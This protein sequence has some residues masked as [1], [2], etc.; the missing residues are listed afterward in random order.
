MLVIELVLLVWTAVGLT[1]WILSCWLVSTPARQPQRDPVKPLP[2]LTVFKALPPTATEKD[3]LRLADAIESFLV[4]IEAGSQMI[5]GIEESESPVWKP[6][7]DRWSERAQDGRLLIRKLGPPPPSINPKI[8]K[9]EVLAAHATGECWLWSDAD[10][11]APAGLLRHLRQELADATVGAVTTV[12]VVRS[13]EQLPGM[14]DA[15]FVNLEFLPG[16]LLLGRKGLLDFA[17]GAA[18][19]F[20][21][22]DFRARVP[23]SD[24]RSVLADDYELGQRLGRVR[25]SSSRVETLALSTRWRQALRHYYR[26]QKTIRW[27]RPGG[28][29]ALLTILPFLGWL[30]AALAWPAAAVFWGGLASVWL[31]EAVVAG[32]MFRKLECRLPA[33]SWLLFAAWPP[34][35]ALTWL[36]VWL[37]FAVGWGEGLEPWRQARRGSGRAARR[38]EVETCI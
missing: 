23:W 36:A 3:R 13:P 9:L 22:A 5:I 27:C 21:A 30:L 38:P 34:L 15:L 17:F 6:I 33:R 1:W 16:A 32:V 4:Q 18:T 24:L 28:Y 35:R 29:L 2:A 37:P 19:L 7:L 10:V 20:R 8:A 31:L 25:L 11:F 14:L 12:Y 26:W